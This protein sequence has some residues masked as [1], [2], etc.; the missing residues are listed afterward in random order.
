MFKKYISDINKLNNSLEGLRDRLTSSLDKSLGNESP[1][2]K[3]A[4]FD[5]VAK[6]KNGDIDYKASQ[7]EIDKLK[8]MQ[9]GNNS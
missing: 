1:E 6:A 5:I 3:K 2:F 8:K 4:V 7:E 9:H